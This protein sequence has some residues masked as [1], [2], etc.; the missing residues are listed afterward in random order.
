MKRCTITL[1]TIA[2]ISLVIMLITTLIA[3]SLS[4]KEGFA[5]GG[6]PAK[7]FSGASMQK[8]GG[9]NYRIDP[10]AKTPDG[11]KM[12]DVP[13][14]KK[15][16]G[17]NDSD[18][19]KRLATIKTGFTGYSFSTFE[20]NT[21]YDLYYESGGA[22][23]PVS[24][25]LGANH[26]LVETGFAIGNNAQ[27]KDWDRKYPLR[28]VLDYI[29][30]DGTKYSS[31]YYYYDGE[32]TY[33]W[34]PPKTAAPLIYDPETRGRPIVSEPKPIITDTQVVQQSPLSST[35]MIE[36]SMSG[37]AMSGSAMSEPA[38]SGSAMSGP[39]GRRPIIINVNNSG[40]SYA[41]QENYPQQGEMSQQMPNNTINVTHELSDESNAKLEKTMNFMEF[42]MKKSQN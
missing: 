26:D 19:Y 4:P 38:M 30:S 15:L 39:E 6:I 35:N 5:G 37:S 42:I 23:H 3:Q 32:F 9:P 28:F 21:W 27:F 40:G 34:P 29:R 33:Q 10:E 8:G 25:G 22:K 31:T 18:Y 11:L 36:P 7:F 16:Q 14:A 17:E 2:L 20:D 24:G 13:V 12:F 1:L 41:P